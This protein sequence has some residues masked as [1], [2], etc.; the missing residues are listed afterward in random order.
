MSNAQ[1]SITSHHPK[2]EGLKYYVTAKQIYL[3]DVQTPKWPLWD[4]NKLE[5]WYKDV[6]E[7]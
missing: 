3:H 5:K 7:N 6:L 2:K 4:I 1:T